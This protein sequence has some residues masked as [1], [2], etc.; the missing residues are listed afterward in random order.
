MHKLDLP[1][2]FIDSSKNTNDVFVYY[3]QSNSDNS[4]SKITLNTN[5]I[6]FLIEGNKELYHNDASQKISENQFVLAKSGN[7]LMSENLSTQKK[8][9][10]LLFFFNQNFI[11]HFK[12]KHATTLLSKQKLILAEKS[13]LVLEYDVFIKNF[14]MSLNQLLESENVVSDAFITLKLEEI[15]LY[16]VQK[17]GSEVLF[18]FDLENQKAERKNI[19]LQGIV[20]R[21]IYSKLS[22]DELA[23]LCDMSLST[24]KREF[25]KVYK[26]SPSKWIQERRLEKS[27][28]LLS[29]KNERPSDV[30]HIIGYESLSSFT[31]SFKQKF[32]TTPKKYQLQVN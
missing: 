7:C 32:G 13:F 31:Q 3:F 12:S 2:L 24:F 18:F 26:M 28:H 22:L 14:V 6:S 20:E 27:A 1:E 5:L 15:L 16:L 11:T 30:Y 4:K 19:K 29:S 21:N 9:S 25:N 10:S 8:Y 23:F 17:F